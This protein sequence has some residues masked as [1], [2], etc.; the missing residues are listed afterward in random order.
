MLRAY[1]GDADLIGNQLMSHMIESCYWKE[2]L[3]RI[4]A[5]IR[6]VAKP[7][8]WTERALCVVERDLMVGLFLL[9][10]LIELNRV[11][12]ATKNMRLRIFSHKARGKLVTQMNGHRIW[13]LYDMENEIAETKKPLYV[14]NQF[15]HTYTSIISRDESRNWSDVYIVSDFDRNDCIWRV[16]IS[17]I[18]S[19]FLTASADYPYMIEKK[20]N[21]KTGDYDVTTN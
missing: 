2:E 20:F 14:S 18:E 1:A 16:P 12:S 13:E 17:L 19:L 9:R 8:R 7:P 11:S 4:A 15:I 5:T 3:R 6:R 10:R 21:P